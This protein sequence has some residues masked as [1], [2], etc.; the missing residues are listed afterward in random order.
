LEFFAVWDFNGLTAIA[1]HHLSAR[2][3][4]RTVLVLDEKNAPQICMNGVKVSDNE[5]NKHNAPRYV[6]AQKPK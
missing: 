2:D 3:C 1:L 6:I 4:A 5:K